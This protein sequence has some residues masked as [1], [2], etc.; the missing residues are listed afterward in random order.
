MVN[1]VKLV[2]SSKLK[3]GTVEASWSDH[4]KNFQSDKN[5]QMIII[6]NFTERINMAIKSVVRFEIFD[7]NIR[8]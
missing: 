1:G 4:C 6:A 5:K 7:Q 2:R 8:I 3:I